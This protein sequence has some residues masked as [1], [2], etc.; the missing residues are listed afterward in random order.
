V[1]HGG[2]AEIHDRKAALLIADEIS[3]YLIA[4]MDP[5]EM[6]IDCG[7]VNHHTIHNISKTETFT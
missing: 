6:E 7:I 4:M 2:V 5:G 3:G 1:V